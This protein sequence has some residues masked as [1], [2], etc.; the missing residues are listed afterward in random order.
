MKTE[1]E[2]RVTWPRTEDA[3]GHQQPGEAGRDASLEPRGQAAPRTV[4]GALPRW[5]PPARGHVS[6]ILPACVAPA[7]G[8]CRPSPPLT[9][10]RALTSARPTPM[11]APAVSCVASMASRLLGLYSL[12]TIESKST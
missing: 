10:A 7:A 9:G 4:R 12:L 3:W 1:A 6:R 2:L 5:E 8:T 11:R